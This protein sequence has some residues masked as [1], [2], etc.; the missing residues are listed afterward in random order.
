MRCRFVTLVTEG[1]HAVPKAP[2]G[3]RRSHKNAVQ[4]TAEGEGDRKRSPLIGPSGTKVE[5]S[6]RDPG[7]QVRS[8][9]ALRY[10]RYRKGD[11]LWHLKDQPL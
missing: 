9:I 2:F 3:D 5:V 11:H 10:Q 4:L 6:L 7:H 8:S 1:D